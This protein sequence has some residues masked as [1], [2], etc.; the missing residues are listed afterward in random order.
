MCIKAALIQSG[1][2][3]SDADIEEVIAHLPQDTGC[4]GVASKVQLIEKLYV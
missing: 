1:I 2:V 3:W 4:K